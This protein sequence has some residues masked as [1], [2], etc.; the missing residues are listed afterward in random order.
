[1]SKNIKDLMSKLKKVY[2]AK[3]R[4]DDIVGTG[5]NILPPTFYIK[6]PKPLQRLMGCHF[7]GRRIIQVSGR[8]NS[9]KTSTAMEAI[10]EAQKG[11]FDQDKKYVE[12]EDVIVIFVDTEKKFNINR[13]IRMGIDPDR[14][15]KIDAGT[16][17]EAAFGIEQSLELIFSEKP[18]AKVLVIIDSVGNTPSAQ[19]AD[20]NIDE[21]TQLA[22]SPKA[23][24]RMLRVINTR[25]MSKKD[26]CMLL[27][28][29]SYANIGSV[30]QVN[31]GG[32]GMEYQ[33]S[34]IIQLTRI[35]DI[36]VTRAGEKYVKGI[37]AKATLT[38]NHNQVA[39]MSLKYIQFEIE[40]DGIKSLDSFNIK[41]GNSF[42]S[43]EDKIIIDKFNTKKDEV[44][45][46]LNGTAYNCTKAEI[47]TILENDNYEEVIKEGDSEE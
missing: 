47:I 22:L 9:G 25:Y 35:G 27:I 30:G 17:E 39:D 40:A 32:S 42:T 46:V 14:L 21:T 28:N 44:T 31:S 7:P 41:N 43:G 1:M 18:K 20:K 13:A 38:K 36:L 6:A 23:I 12:S 4:D 8:P 45:Y 3:K 5:A 11:Y 19:E 33:S 29:T 15:M 34:I 24:K 37:K 26:V 16:I 10:R 2:K